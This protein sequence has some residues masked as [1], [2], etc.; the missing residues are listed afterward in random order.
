V[1]QRA[2]LEAQHAQAHNE[3]IALEEAQ[4]LGWVY[5]RLFQHTAQA[6]G[7]D[8]DQ[9]AFLH[10]GWAIQG[11][12]RVLEAFRAD[13]AAY[14]QRLVD[15]VRE[16]AAGWQ[17]EQIFARWTPPAHLEPSAS[18]F[19]Q[20]LQALLAAPTGLLGDGS[21][22]ARALLDAARAELVRELPAALEELG[23]T[24]YEPAAGAPNVFARDAASVQRAGGPLDQGWQQIE[25]AELPK[26]ARLLP[27]VVAQL[28]V[29]TPDL[30][31]PAWNAYTARFGATGGG[32][33]APATAPPPAEGGGN[34]D[35][36][37]PAVGK[38][39]K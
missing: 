32:R 22:L 5:A 34:N 27:A 30:H 7:Q 35:A 16:V 11:L 13:P 38:T 10:P 4:D 21:A 9:G 29:D 25:A 12:G 1:E 18:G 19:A 33:A 23:E 6:L 37:K 36:N 28:V 24:Y 17:W 26:M 15:K 39:G 8:A 31:A 14:H 3:A 20:A 2:D